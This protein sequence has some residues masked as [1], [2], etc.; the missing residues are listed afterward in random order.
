[1]ILRTSWVVIYMYNLEQK[2]FHSYSF[3]FVI[4]DVPEML[5]SVGFQSFLRFHGGNL[6]ANSSLL[7]RLLRKALEWPASSDAYHSSCNV[8]TKQIGLEQG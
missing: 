1:M 6:C 5:L 4:T 7:W 8:I 3:K 2:L